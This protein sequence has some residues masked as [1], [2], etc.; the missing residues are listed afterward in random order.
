MAK[1]FKQ[2]VPL[3]GFTGRQFLMMVSNVFTKLGWPYVFQDEQT[4]VAEAGKFNASENVTVSV[5]GDEAT[6]HSKC[7][8]WYIT[9]LG[10]N[11][12]HVNKLIGEIDAA[13]Q[14]YTAE[15]LDEQYNEI[16]QQTIAETQAL[17]E[18]IERGELTASDKITLGIGGHYVTYTLIG[19]NLLVFIAMA[20]SGVSIIDPT[21]LDI[22][23]WGG[24][25]RAYTASG[26]WWRLITSVF[27]HIGIIHLLLNMYA[28]YMI[29]LYL[30]PILGRWKFLAAYLSA[31]VLA[32]LTSLW[33]HDASVGAGASGAIFGM[34]GLFVALLTTSLIDKKLRGGLMQ[35]MAVFVVYNLIYGLKGNI[36]NAAHIG[37]LVSGFVL[38]YIYYFFQ[39]KDKEAKMFPAVAI[40]LAIVATMGMLRN[41]NDDSVKFD[42][43]WE[44]FAV[45]EEKGIKVMTQRDSLTAQEFIKMAETEGIPTWVQIKDLLKKTDDYKLPADRS[46]Q[47]TLLKEYA[48]LRL[49]YLQ[50]WVKWEKDPDDGVLSTM[51]KVNDS[52]KTVLADM[53]KIK[54]Q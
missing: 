17:K 27:V 1:E 31:G 29:G 14:E 54:L 43:A 12:K 38:G 28:L 35:S 16:E 18:R 45:L 26:E 8:S 30:E 10:R 19:I 37:G 15:Q 49:R 48:D 33:W 23:N 39:K 40:A 44:E 4:V 21:G 2:N 6:I 47:R 51:E 42:K 9:D 3:N 53:E 46:Q 32:S 25:M 36:D 7:N 34:Y 22:L 5:A 50:L 13:R 24:N 20:V 41:Y 11:K 52:V